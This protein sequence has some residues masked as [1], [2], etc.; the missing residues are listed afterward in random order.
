MQKFLLINI[1]LFAAS[2]A[3]AYVK[4][5]DRLERD[6]EHNPSGKRLVVIS[7]CALGLSFLFT[8]VSADAGIIML[9]L[10]VLLIAVL[11]GTTAGGSIAWRVFQKRNPDL[12]EEE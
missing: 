3:L 1:L 10:S 5:I 7:L 2:C 4:E 8:L 6:E 9:T 11:A 12:F